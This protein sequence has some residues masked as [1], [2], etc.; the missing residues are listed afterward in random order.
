RGIRQGGSTLTQQLVKNL[1]LTQQRTLLR[2][3][4]EAVLAVLLETRY[5]K[6]EILESYLTE[7]YLGSSGGVSVLGT[8]AAARAF[9]GKDASD[10]DLAESATLA[11]MIRSPAPYSP[12]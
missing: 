6:R 8:G 3:A 12:V 9:L 5:D 1:F 7:I 11:G 2:K 4:E 10:L